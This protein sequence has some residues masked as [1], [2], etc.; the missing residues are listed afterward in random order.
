MLQANNSGHLRATAFLL[1]CCTLLLYAASARSQYV[2]A[3]TYTCY[4]LLAPETNSFRIFYEVTETSPGARFHFNI[5]RP[6]SEASDEAVYDLATGK[7][8]KFE[9]VTGAQAKTD[10]PE[11]NFNPTARYIKV[12]LAHPV[13][14]R[15]EYR[16]RIDKTYKDKESYYS[17]GDHIVFKRGLGIPRN[18]VVLPT[19]YEIVSSSVAAQVIPE[20]DGRLKLA[21][22]NAGSGGQLDAQIV[23][24]RL[25]ALAAKAE[26]KAEWKPA[27]PA[28]SQPTTTTQSME[29]VERANQDREILYELPE[30]PSHAFRITH[31]YTERR[32]GSKHYFNVVRA[33]S[34]VSDPESIDLD[35]GENLKWETLTGKQIKERKLPLPDVKE[36]AEV[37]VT[38]FAQPVAR[39]SS[40]RLRLKETYTDPKSYYLDGDELVWDRSFGRLRNTVVL[41]PGWHLTALESP[42]TIQTL[43]DGRVSVYIVNP[44]NDD[45]RVYLRARRRA[46]R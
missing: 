44:R 30:P 20:P 39:G 32:E 5:I 28:S 3:D 26:K 14:A 43:S 33:G 4:E 15:G 25:P 35:S 41:P 18:S 6:G 12:H 16:L 42:A 36:N 23:A 37:V 13:P 9:V 31:D 19:G 22:V 1:A 17:D 38:H 34:R 21:F 10:S 2:S 45:V 8:L 24:R 29:I 27:S 40:V 46:A 7:P 11:G